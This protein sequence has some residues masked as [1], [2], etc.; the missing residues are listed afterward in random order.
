MIGGNALIAM[1]PSYFDDMAY[2]EVYNAEVSTIIDELRRSHTQLGLYWACCGFVA[3]NTDDKNWNS[4]Q[5]VSDQCLI[6]ARMVEEYMY[7]KNP[8]TGV[9]SL[10]L[11][12]KSIA[13][14]NLAHWDAC[15]YFTE[16]FQI[17]ADKIGT[18][19]DDLIEAAQKRMRSRV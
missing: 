6:A 9:E 18:S 3:D 19:V 12:L 10:H 1:A 11:R 5:K 16:A 15:G 13:F 8:K 7:Y 2:G 17:M 4:K 14:R